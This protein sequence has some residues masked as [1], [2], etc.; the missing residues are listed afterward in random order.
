MSLPEDYCQFQKLIECEV[1]WNWFK[2]RHSIPLIHWREEE[3]VKV[4]ICVIPDIV[5]T[6]WEIRASSHGE[7]RSEIQCSSV[8]LLITLLS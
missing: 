1:I 2:R 5:S 7:S 4:A 3:K 8:E 6:A